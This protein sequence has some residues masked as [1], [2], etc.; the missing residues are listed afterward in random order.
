[1]KNN[2]SQE[3]DV[4][5]DVKSPIAQEV[6]EDILDAWNRQDNTEFLIACRKLQQYHQDFVAKIIAYTLEECQRMFA[7]TQ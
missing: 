1:M 4:L 6:G 7:R 5:F 3:L 2:K